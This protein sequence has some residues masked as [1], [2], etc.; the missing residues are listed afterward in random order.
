[1]HQPAGADGQNPQPG[2]FPSQ[3]SRTARTVHAFGDDALGDH[4]AT[5]LAELV[6]KRRVSPGELASAAV[7]RAGRIQAF[8]N[9]VHHPDYERAVA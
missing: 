8:V 5:A 1:M 7:A 3:A 4:D 2:A 6:V 9:G